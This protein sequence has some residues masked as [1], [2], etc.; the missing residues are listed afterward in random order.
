RGPG[1]KSSENHIKSQMWT[2][3]FSD[4]FLIGSEEIG[5]NWE[6]HHKFPGNVGCGSSRSDFA[7]VIFNGANQQFPFF[8]TEFENDGFA[9][10][11]D[12]VAVVAETAFEYD[13]MLAV[14]YYLSEDESM[15]K[16]SALIYAY[17]DNGVTFKLHTGDQQADIASVLKLVAYLRT[18]VYHDGVTLNMQFNRTTDTRNGALLASLPRLP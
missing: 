1:S 7:A 8:I 6:Y 13:R 10:Y 4:S 9:V 11:K 15:M 16:Q 18:N 12:A 5:V 3:I 17:E 14:A 2:K